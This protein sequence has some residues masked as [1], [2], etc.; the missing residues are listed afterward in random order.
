MTFFTNRLYELKLILSESRI[1]LT[2][3]IYPIVKDAYLNL[4]YIG[5]AQVIWNLNQVPVSLNLYCHE[6]QF[7]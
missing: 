2:H 3:N 1:P 6:F 4:L 7:A 5:K